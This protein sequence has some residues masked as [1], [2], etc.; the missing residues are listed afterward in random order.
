MPDPLMCFSSTPKAS[1]SQPVGQTT[2]SQ[3]LYIRWP[4]Y[5][6]CIMIHN[7]SKMTVMKSLTSLC[8]CPLTYY[9]VK[10]ISKITNNTEI[11]SYFLLNLSL[12]LS[13]KLANDTV[14]PQ[15]STSGAEKS[16]RYPEISFICSTLSNKA[17]NPHAPFSVTQFQSAHSS[18]PSMAILPMYLLPEDSN[19][20]W[21]FMPYL[22]PHAPLSAAARILLR[23]NHILSSY[24]KGFKGSLW[25]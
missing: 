8:D 20:S 19:F 7:S 23:H 16:Q 4:A 9:N 11:F 22:V 5:Q 15:S 6:I 14:S 25:T 21:C 12:N 2:L 10:D 13:P 17:A 1:D 18:S 3:E 24:L